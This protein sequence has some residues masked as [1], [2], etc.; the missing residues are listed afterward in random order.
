VILIS[1]EK[2]TFV[3]ILVFVFLFLSVFA[4]CTEEKSTIHE[5]FAFTS[6]EGETKYLSDYR[7]KVVI[8]DMWATWCGPCKL[9]LIEFQSV[10][11]SYSRDDVEILSIDIDQRE[12]AE[13]VQSFLSDFEYA[14]TFGLDNGSIWETYKGASGSIPT[15][16]IFDRNG[17]LSF[18][19]EGLLVQT[20]LTPILD[21]LL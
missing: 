1:V 7:G 14:W 6:L 17:T 5:G 8:L 4:G 3:F 21:K 13:L 19:H 20:K 9:Q 15:L 16:C 2:P 10:Y 18:S 12:T 11:E